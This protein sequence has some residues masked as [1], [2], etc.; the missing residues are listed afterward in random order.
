[1]IKNEREYRITQAAA[2]RF[3][4]SIAA[5]EQADRPM[6]V[7][8]RLHRASM[9]AMRAQLA[10]LE[11]ELRDFE[12]LQTRTPLLEANA[13]ELGA[14]LIRA[15]IAR[16]WTERE[17]AERL[18]LTLQQVRQDEAT[19]Y[20]SASLTRLREVCQALGATLWVEARLVA[21]NTPPTATEPPQSAGRVR[22]DDST[23]N[24]PDTTK[25]RR[26]RSKDS[27]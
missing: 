11:R 5:A 8:P 19:E 13:D 27:S 7:G 26:T 9:E 14:L 25:D 1:M 20:E 12:A 16:G 24:V 22:G 10:E 23:R 3:R 21:L 6:R 4:A 17:L 18:G 15:R 2:A